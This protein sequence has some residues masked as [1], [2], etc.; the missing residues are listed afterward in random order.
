MITIDGKIS[1][2]EVATIAHGT[3]SVA[4]GHDVV[5]RVQ[6]AYDRARELVQTVPTYGRT[7][8]VGAN[9]VLAVEE[10]DSEHGIRLLRSHAVDAGAPLSPVL[11]RAMLSVRLAQL[12][13]PGSGIN[14]GV[15]SGLE[16]MLN[17]NALPSVL[18]FGSIGTADTSALAGT[19]LTLM[20]ERPASAPLDPMPRWE[21]D[22]AL[23]FMSSSALTLGRACLAAADLEQLVDANS[24]S[25]ALSF[26]GLRGNR[27]PQCSI[28]TAAIAAPGATEVNARLNS[29][30]GA[31]GEAALIQ[32]P[33]ALRAYPA[34]QTP[35]WD[36]SARFQSLLASLINVA[37]ENPLFVD[38]AD[39]PQVVHHGGFFQS[40]LAVMIDSITIALA[41]S[42]P[43]A[44]SRI[45]MMT[46]PS[47]SGASP[48]LA[49]GPQGSSGIMMVEYV[50]A[51]AYAEMRASAAPSAV[52]T[53][54]VSRGT[55]EDASFASQSVVQLER[56]LR[57][58]R[59]V[60]ACEIVVAARL[61]RQRGV[62]SAALPSPALQRVAAVLAAL[63]QVDKDRELRTDL[64]TAEELIEKVAACV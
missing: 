64:A 42:I 53:A 21:S 48:F 30:L 7:T 2:K 49:D 10:E 56:S 39:G 45:R 13:H 33:F 29:L 24:V 1:V 4:L 19:A 23:S 16:R 43:T 22:S 34:I 5:S 61:L 14:P 55:E 11:V 62:D 26:V 35:L 44:L 36:L 27:S 63:P 57:A 9:R 59:T 32:D 60:I 37:A 28:A 31:T 8:G 12:A 41:Q 51:S 18:E 6:V 50:A 38:S 52:T 46:E 3:E 58:Y 15:L 20:G 40:S 25:F 47:Y 54:V 17:S